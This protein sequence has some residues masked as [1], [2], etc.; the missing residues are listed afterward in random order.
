[1]KRVIVSSLKYKNTQ[2]IYIFN[3]ENPQNSEPQKCPRRGSD[4]IALAHSNVLVILQGV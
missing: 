3:N 4:F 2:P 1:M